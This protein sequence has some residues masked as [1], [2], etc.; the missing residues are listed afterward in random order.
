LYES[1]DHKPRCESAEY[2]LDDAVRG[3]DYQIGDQI[4]LRDEHD[5]FLMAGI[6]QIEPAVQVDETGRYRV[7]VIWTL[8]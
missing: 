4:G 5:G 1:R 3:W 8:D 2:Q 7:A 6:G